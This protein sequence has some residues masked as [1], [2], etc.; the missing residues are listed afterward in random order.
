MRRKSDRYAG[1]TGK[2]KAKVY[3]KSGQRVETA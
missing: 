3:E 1:T 2:A